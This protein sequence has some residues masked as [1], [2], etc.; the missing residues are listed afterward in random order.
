MPSVASPM[1]EAPLFLLNE[2]PALV[3]ALLA[4]AGFDPPAFT[5]ASVASADFTQAV[6]LERRADAAITLHDGERV[7]MGILLEVQLAAR[8]EKRF[9]WPFYLASLHARLRCPSLLVVLAPYTSVADWA[10]QPIVTMQP[11]SPFLPF[12]LGPDSIPRIDDALAARQAPELAVLAA[13]VHGAR[14]D[15]RR[16]VEAAVDAAAHLDDARA[17][18]Y[19]DLI[20]SNLGELARAALEAVMAQGKWEYQ[21]EFAKKYFAEGRVEGRVEGREEGREEGR[22][23]AARRLLRTVLAARAVSLSQRAIDAIESESDEG[24]LEEWTARAAVAT[25]E[26]DVFGD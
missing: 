4:H 15:G 14:P 7:V 1:H 25:S 24:T 26:G 9:A 8:E 6:P 12:V 17:A 16:V 19:F 2:R 21:S 10:R 5:H 13:I 23:E 22:V 11:T 18:T 20:Y 3:A